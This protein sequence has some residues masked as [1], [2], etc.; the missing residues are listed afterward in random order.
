MALIMLASTNYASIIGQ[1]MMIGEAS[2][3]NTHKTL[4][5]HNRRQNI[6]LFLDIRLCPNHMIKLYVGTWYATPK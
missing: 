6:L 3:M 5:K 1:A 2:K 4:P